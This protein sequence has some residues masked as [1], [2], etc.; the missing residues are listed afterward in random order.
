MH[1]K[2]GSAQLYYNFLKMRGNQL[3]IHLDRSM[4]DAEKRHS[5]IEK[6]LLGINYGCCR[7]IQFI[8]EGQIKVEIDHKSLVSLAK[9]K[10]LKSYI[11]PRHKLGWSFCC[12]K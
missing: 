7:F 9:T 3:R 12:H 8:Y 10:G 1:Q 2:M 11:I 6:E 4:I 5:Q